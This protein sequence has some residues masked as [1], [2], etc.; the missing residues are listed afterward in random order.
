MGKKEPNPFEADLERVREACRAVIAASEDLE[1]HRAKVS[2]LPDS[3]LKRGTLAKIDSVRSQYLPPEV[4]PPQRKSKQ[5]YLA[6]AIVETGA[7]RQFRRAGRATD[8][9]RHIARAQRA[10][11]KARVR[12]NYEP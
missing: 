2:R 7:A 5:D 12:D 9:E 8:V 10:M 1:R 4:K 11:L 3:Q 6:D